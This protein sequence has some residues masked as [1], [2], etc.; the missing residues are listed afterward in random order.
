M[1]RISPTLMVLVLALTVSACGGEVGTL[2]SGSTGVDAPDS[3]PDVA[4]VV[5]TTPPS[6]APMEDSEIDGVDADA[7]LED[8][9]SADVGEGET[10]ETPDAGNQGLDGDVPG[11]DVGAD[12]GALDLD[13]TGTEDT[14]VAPPVDAAGDVVTEEPD[15]EGTWRSALYP[16]D[17]TPAYTISDVLFLHDFSYA[18]YHHG[19]AA[20]PTVPGPV[21]TILDTGAD[22]SGST[23]S[24]A[25]IQDSLSAASA[26]G[27]GVVLVPAGTYRCDGQLEVTSS[28]VVLRG[29]GPAISRLHFTKHNAMSDKSHIL[30]QGSPTLLSEHALVEDGV[31]RGTTLA[32]ADA[33]GL[34]VGDDLQIGW[35]I[36][37]AF[38][39]AHGMTGTWLAFNGTWQP[40][41]RREIV[42]VDT[43]VTPHLITVDVPLRYPALVSD[44]ASV[45]RISGLLE[46]VGVEG[47]GVAN[48]VGW[49]AAWSND[50][51][52]VLE[53]KGVKDSW[54]R[55]VESFVSPGAPGSGD[56]AGSHLQS[57]GILVHASNRVT[58]QNSILQEAQNRGSGGN[59]Y[60]FEVR[61]SSEVLFVDNI[62]RAGRHNFIQNWGFGLTGTVWL[63]CTSSDGF[64]ASSEGTA[65]L[66]Q[67]GY[68]EF[69]HSL[70]TGNLI[71][72]C[73]LDDG[74]KAVNRNDYSTGAGHTATQTVF[75]NNTG[76]GKLVS[77]Q[78]NR[79]HVIGS[80]GEL[81]VDVD[82]SGGWG[83]Q[84][85]DGTA[86]EDFSEGIGMG[87]T[88]YPPSLFESQLSKRLGL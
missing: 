45:R 50:R 23:D 6:D 42:S 43:D 9:G 18:G 14:D 52:H 58:V 82:V 39:E 62:A 55:D 85:G 63:R 87:A 16:K 70:A 73:I 22:P 74:F 35:E 86:P 4:E 68:S 41:F 80:S 24:T 26:A 64:A 59:G 38:I 28:H 83:S 77:R 67:I 65:W 84:D 69:H 32:V 8:S 75:W 15:P 17:W 46:E 3:S 25:A 51:N 79:G 1:K 78:F 33:A 49:A 57:G 66:G 71:D 19:E 56:G 88:L 13:S 54:I 72:S 12:S 27:G 11:A 7:P 31:N 47:I 61:T 29:E 60:L 36:T 2:A 30:F 76:A 48:A 40:F 44:L 10:G 5:D 21:F 53:M 20:I 37:D 81:E 34:A